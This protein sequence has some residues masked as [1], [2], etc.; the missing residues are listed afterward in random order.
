[1]DKILCKYNNQ[2]FS[3]TNID[4]WNIQKK[5]ILFNIRNGIDKWIVYNVAEYEFMEKTGLTTRQLINMSEL[6]ITNLHL[7]ID[8]E[9]WCKETACNIIYGIKGFIQGMIDSNIW[10]GFYKTYT[11]QELSNIIYYSIEN[12]IETFRYSPFLIDRGI[13]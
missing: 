6:I 2:D 10:V 5:Q 13:L 3:I 9:L 4:L 12:Q 8:N 7:L 11:N 1:M